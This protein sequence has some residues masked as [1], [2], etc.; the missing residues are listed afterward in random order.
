MA[1]TCAFCRD[2]TDENKQSI[3]YLETFYTEFITQKATESQL[4][5]VG[6]NIKVNAP[7]KNNVPVNWSVCTN[8]FSAL[9]LLLKSKR[10]VDKVECQV[11]KLQRRLLMELQSLSKEVDIMA[12]NMVVVEGILRRNA[13]DYFPN[14]WK[15]EDGQRKRKTKEEIEEESKLVEQFRDKVVNGKGYKFKSINN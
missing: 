14:V 3:N 11:R 9:Q 13:D 8:C 2:T 4:K 7:V 6:G 12:G 1:L 5:G 15:E 10:A